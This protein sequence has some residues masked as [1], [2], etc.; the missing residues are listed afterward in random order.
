MIVTTSADKLSW[1]WESGYW[2]EDVASAY[3]VLKQ[4]GYEVDVSSIKGGEAPI[5][6][7]SFNAGWL[8]ESCQRFLDDDEAQGLMC[9]APKLDK[10]AKTVPSKY[11]IVIIAGGL[12]AYEDYVSN[13]A[14]SS[15]IS[16]VLAAGGVVGTVGLGGIALRGVPELVKGKELTCLSETELSL[17]GLYTEGGA[18][19]KGEKYL[20]T[21]EHHVNEHRPRPLPVN[22]S[23]KESPAWRKPPT[24]VLHEEEELEF[25]MDEAAPFVLTDEL[26]ALGCKVK[27]LVPFVGYVIVTHAGEGHLVTAQ[28]SKG[29]K[30]LAQKCVEK[31][32]GLKSITKFKG[33][34]EQVTM[35]D[36]EL[37][38]VANLDPSKGEYI[39]DFALH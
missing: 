10:I 12:G 22:D 21:R 31:A 13:K 2:L 5:D 29:A 6:P 24:I 17:L 37:F 3:Y 16:G 4:T 11:G 14:L 36:H 35:P 30:A 15:V 25:G 38:K 23:L 9:A 28:N 18:G 19:S 34:K 39:P 20:A 33:A 27:T 26:R 32:L 7:L 1:A 8:T